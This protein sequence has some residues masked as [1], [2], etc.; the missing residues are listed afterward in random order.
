[1]RNGKGR[2]QSLITCTSYF[3]RK[4][5]HSMRRVLVYGALF[6]FIWHSRLSQAHSFPHFITMSLTDELDVVP[7]EIPD[8]DTG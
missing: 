2:I 3:S 5:L 4:A 6:L 1:M 7:H 8:Y